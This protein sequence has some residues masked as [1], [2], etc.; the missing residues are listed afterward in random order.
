[1]D[2]LMRSLGFVSSSQKVN[3]IRLFVHTHKF[4]VEDPSFFCAHVVVRS[5]EWAHAQD[6]G[7]PVA[8]ENQ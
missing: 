3:F 6:E 2:I 8:P 1:M 7:S 5:T 4:I